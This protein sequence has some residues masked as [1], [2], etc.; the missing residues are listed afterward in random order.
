MERR[1]SDALQRICRSYL[2]KLMP[3][4]RKF[5]LET[6]VSDLIL[7]NRRRECE[8]TETEVELLSRACD[9]ERLHRQDVPTLLGKSYRQSY[10][11]RDFEKIKKLKRVGIYSKIGAILLGEELKAISDE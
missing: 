4:A 1:R 3:V 11:E 8:A 9:D 5:G 6:F 7:K 10:E 2:L